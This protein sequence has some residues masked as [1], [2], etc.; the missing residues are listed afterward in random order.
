M[1]PVIAQYD[2]LIV[3]LHN[4]EFMTSVDRFPPDITNW[5]GLTPFNKIL[6]ARTRMLSEAKH[7]ADAL[8]AVLDV[9]E[10][11]DHPLVDEARATLEEI[12]NYKLIMRA[13]T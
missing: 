4:A 13:G 7:L 8:L 12:A 9:L 10:E 3:W 11:L 6:S 5:L 2:R 1:L